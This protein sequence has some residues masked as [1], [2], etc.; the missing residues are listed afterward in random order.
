MTEGE[1]LS[2]RVFDGGGSPGD[3][4]RV[5]AIKI[6]EALLAE[7]VVFHSLFDTLEQMLPRMRSLNEVR[8][9]AELLESMLGAHSKVED[10]LIIEPLDHCFE[11]FGQQETFHQEHEEID[12]ALALCLKCRD[13]RKARRLLMDVVVA[14]RNHFDKEERLVFPMAE[15]ALNAKTLVLLGDRWREERK[16]IVG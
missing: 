15:K 5:M 8:A 13:L 4:R 10:Q 2:H 3:A 14:S 7:H 6:T 16:A 1:R 9:L 12:A 11:E